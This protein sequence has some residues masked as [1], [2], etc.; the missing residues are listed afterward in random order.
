MDTGK[1]PFNSCS[2]EETEGLGEALSKNLSRGNRIGLVGELGA[3]KTAFV[4]GI[5]RGLG[6]SCPVKSPSFSIL[7][8]YE[9]GRLP[10]YHIDLYRLNTV[11]EFYDA[12]LGEYF[13]N[14]GVCVVEWADRVPEV[15]SECDVVVR[16]SWRS[17]TLREIEVK[18]VFDKEAG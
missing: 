14:N 8:I 6:A 11:N 17:E 3:G 18:A 2:P 9:G 5:A 10:L 15:L 1:G 16:F 12:G 4:R 13:F 7:N